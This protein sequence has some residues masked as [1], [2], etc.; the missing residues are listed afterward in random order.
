MSQQLYQIQP[1]H[2]CKRDA[3]KRGAKLKGKQEFTCLYCGATLQTAPIEES[4]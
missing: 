2:N 3:W 1:C 4:A